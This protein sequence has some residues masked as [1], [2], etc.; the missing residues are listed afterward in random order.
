[1]AVELASPT[2]ENLNRQAPKL[3]GLDDAQQIWECSFTY[4]TQP[5]QSDDADGGGGSPPADTPE[6]S[7]EYDS[8]GATFHVTQSLE[9]T[10]KVSFVDQ[11]VPDHK[12]AIGVSKDSGG[13]H[14][15]GVDVPIPDGIVTVTKN[16][17]SN[18]INGAYRKGVT[19]LRGKTNAAAYSIDGVTYKP[20]ELLCLGARISARGKAHWELTATF[21]I[22]EETEIEV[23]PGKPKVKKLGHHHLWVQYS[24]DTDAAGTQL[25]A[26]PQFAFVERI[27]PA[28]DF[29]QVLGFPEPEPQP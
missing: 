13:V 18:Q 14:V 20:N 2:Y 28:V 16:F 29:L 22:D 24:Q 6:N 25:L 9:T 23:V 26:V 21:Q 12:R 5:I 27:F 11:A 15:E 7:I 17:L 4:N 19:T 1:M 10:A 3:R 8:G